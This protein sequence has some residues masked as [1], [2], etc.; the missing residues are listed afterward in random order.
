MHTL[1]RSYV[2]E[3]RIV[4][5]FKKTL[6]FLFDTIK[7]FEKGLQAAR[8]AEHNPED[9]ETIIRIMTLD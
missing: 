5:D 8:A 9:H 2:P 3:K 1:E 7:V 6:L 4:I